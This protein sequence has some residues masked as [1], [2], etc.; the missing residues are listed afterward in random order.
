MIGGVTIWEIVWTGGLPR[1]PTSSAGHFSPK[2]ALSYSFNPK[3]VPL[4]KFLHI[5]AYHL[6]LLGLLTLIF[7]TP[8]VKCYL[9]SF[10]LCFGWPWIAQKLFHSLFFCRHHCML[11]QLL[12][13]LALRE[14]SCFGSPHGIEKN[15]ENE[16]ELLC[17][18]ICRWFKL[19]LG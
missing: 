4:T 11:I 13:S 6:N 2:Q 12:F 7:L 5:T 17:N 8:K 19:C 10:L 15:N 3:I 14:K 18:V 1:L 16:L 9:S